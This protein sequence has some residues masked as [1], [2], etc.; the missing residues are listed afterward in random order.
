MRGLTL[1]LAAAMT[2]VCARAEAA[3]YTFMPTAIGANIVTYYTPDEAVFTISISDAA[4]QTGSFA[5]DYRLRYV[6]TGNPPQTAYRPVAAGDVQVLQSFQGY[7][8]RINFAGG[9]GPSGL[10]GDYFG[11]NLTFSSTG[12]ITSGALTYRDDGIGYAIDVIDPARASAA[13]SASV[14]SVELLSPGC[15]QTV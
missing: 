11:V 6:E 12:Q 9:G 1:A 2:V 10:D 4:V 14:L 8:G 13:H 15:L 5:Y 7:L 3:V